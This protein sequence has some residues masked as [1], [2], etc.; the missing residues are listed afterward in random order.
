[1]PSSSPTGDL[2]ADLIP[3]HEPSK[4]AQREQ[5]KLPGAIKYRAPRC[6]SSDRM[7][8]KIRQPGQ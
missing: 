8:E 1:M 2:E 5:S 6:D 7:L 3:K 4:R